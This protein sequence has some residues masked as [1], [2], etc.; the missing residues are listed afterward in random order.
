M[1]MFVLTM[2]EHTWGIAVIGGMIGS[3]MQFISFSKIG[4]AG[5]RLDEAAEDLREIP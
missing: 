5:E 1:G 3:V 4:K 2:D